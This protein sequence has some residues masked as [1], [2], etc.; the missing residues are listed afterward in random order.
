MIIFAAP[1]NTAIFHALEQGWLTSDYLLAVI[2][3]G[4]HDLIW[5]KTKDGRK[6]RRRP[7]RLPRPKRESKDGTTSSG[8]G[9]VSVLTVEEFEAKRTARM[10]AWVERKKRE[11]R[12]GSRLD[13][14]TSWP[15]VLPETSR[16]R[17]MIKKALRNVD[18]DAKVTPTVD[19]KGAE[20]SGRAYGDKF[21]GGFERSR[22]SKLGAWV[23]AL[24]GGFKAATAGSI[25]L[26]RN[27]GTISAV[28][29][30]ASRGAKMLSLSL[31]GAAGGMK[32]L[33][34]MGVGEVAAGLGIAA[35]QAHRLSQ[36]VGRVTSA[37][38]VLMAVGK[39]LGVMNKFAKI[40]A[41]LTIGGTA[42][43][44]VMAAL[45]TTIGQAL[46]LALTVAGA[47]AGVFAGAAVGLL[48]PAI[49]VLKLGFKGLEEGAKAF[50]GSMKDSWGPA[51]EAFNKMIGERMGPLLTKFRELRMAVVD[52]FSNALVPAFGS[53]DWL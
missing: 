51:D 6:N 33:A 48:G 31:L 7:K 3:D 52:T 9:R 12:K 41:M 8:L 35:H 10:K 21:A 22:A 28:T 49:G 15:T 23:G 4:I 40:T 42:L 1:P 45:A 29:Q 26:I 2:G 14:S 30:V 46:V 11:A 13:Q 38:L 32:V 25:G 37:L 43:L 47:A 19:S 27:I 24:G 20:S 18:E 50:G 39:V 53:L 34:G 5:Q 16:L 44:G 36:A 17:P